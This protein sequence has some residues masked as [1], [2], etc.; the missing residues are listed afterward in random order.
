MERGCVLFTAHAQIISV[1]IMKKSTY[2]SKSYNDRSM[3]IHRKKAFT[4]LQRMISNRHI[5]DV[6]I[7]YTHKL[8]MAKTAILQYKHCLS[9][10]G[11]NGC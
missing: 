9:H 1:P 11:K 4:C 6:D 3:M 8:Q 10:P 5:D 7:I 2:Y